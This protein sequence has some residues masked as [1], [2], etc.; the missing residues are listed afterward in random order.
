MHY[1]LEKEPMN[2]NNHKKTS[3]LPTRCPRRIRTGRSCRQLRTRRTSR[4]ATR[5][6]RGC[7]CR[8]A[9]AHRFPS[10]IPYFLQTL[11]QHGI[12][13]F[14]HIAIHFIPRFFGTFEDKGLDFHVLS[15]HV[16]GPEGVVDWWAVGK[17]C[18]ADGWL[19]RWRKNGT[20]GWL[21]GWRG[22]GVRGWA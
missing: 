13:P 20:I 17:G 7:L 16:I 21:G 8:I 9:R 18:G 2:N 11:S 22:C 10:N 4:P 6:Q 5:T 14:G 15:C 3:H 12:I 19:G 1:G